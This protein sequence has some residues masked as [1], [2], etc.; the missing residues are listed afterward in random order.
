MPLTT[1]P[2]NGGAGNRTTR[3]KRGGKG[4]YRGD[5]RGSGDNTSERD[6]NKKH[7][8]KGLLQDSC[9]KG[10]VITDNS[11]VRPTQY[12]KFITA[13]PGFCADKGYEGLDEI[14]RTGEDWDEDTFFTPRRNPN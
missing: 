5:K 4:T 12:Q 11:N 7:G 1:Q 2:S 14:I 9:L 13:L 10:I 6:N 3:R 8:F